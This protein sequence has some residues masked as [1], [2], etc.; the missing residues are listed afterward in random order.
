[1]LVIFLSCVKNKKKTF[2]Y[3]T[4]YFTQCTYTNIF[5]IIL[6]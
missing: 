4:A 2:I 3:A 5:T 6:Y 1:M